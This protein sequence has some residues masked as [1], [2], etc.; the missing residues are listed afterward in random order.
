MRLLRITGLFTVFAAIAVSGA[1]ALAVDDM[2]PLPHDGVVGRAYSYQYHGRAGCPP[3]HWWTSGGE[4]PPGLKLNADSGQITGTPTTPGSFRYWI[5]LG[6]SCNTQPANR[7]HTINILRGVMIEQKTLDPA[8]VNV[9]Y[10]KQFTLAAGSDQYASVTWS[11][12][13]GPLPPDLNL[14][15]S[16]LLSGTPT[17]AG[18]YTFEI[19][20]K[21][22]GNQ[23]RYDHQQL[24]LDVVVPLTATQPVAVPKAEVGFLFVSSAPTAAGGKAP[25]TWSAASLPPGL[26]IDAATG[27]L[28]GRPTAAGKFAVRLTATDSLGN[29]ANVDLNLTVAARLALTTKKLPV[30]VTGR[31]YKATLKI[32]GGVKPTSFEIIR[33][34]LPRGIRLNARTGVIVGR[35][36]NVGRY[37]IT[38]RVT[39]ALGAAST[40]KLM[41]TVKQGRV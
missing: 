2:Y 28:S 23:D 41:L 17:T 22:V 14:S 38:F 27:A 26:A 8:T 25:Y 15:T 10:S 29:T 9:P 21:D 1:I 35:T 33:G 13:K 11:V 32:A 7:L 34:N 19:M 4:L 30:V 40:K 12:S 5:N 36:A 6:D 39:D 20:V 3:Y 37:R 16:G 31:K 24:T 18:S